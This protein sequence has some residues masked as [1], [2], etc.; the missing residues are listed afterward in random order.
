MVVVG[1]HSVVKEIQ[2]LSIGKEATKH[3]AIVVDK[4][5]CGAISTRNATTRADPLDTIRIITDI[6]P[7]Y[8][9]VGGVVVY[10]VVSYARGVDSGTNYN[11]H[12]IKD[13]IGAVKTE[14]VNIVHTKFDRL[15]SNLAFVSRIILKL[16][17]V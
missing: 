16:G 7:W 12:H 8:V 11:I 9:L 6:L 4:P 10:E 1:D 3:R 15:V 17:F 14:V 5:I 13:E 2:G